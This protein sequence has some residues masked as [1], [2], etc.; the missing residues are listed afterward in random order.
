MERDARRRTRAGKTAAFD[1]FEAL[2][3]LVQRAE[4]DLNDALTGLSRGDAFGTAAG[5]WQRAELGLRRGARG[6]FG[7]WF[8][9][10]NL[11]TR[12]DVIRLGRRLAEIEKQLAR[13]EGN[14][15]A[16]PA[17]A[18]ASAARTR[19]P[20]RRHDDAAS[21]DTGERPRRTRKPPPP[22]PRPLAAPRA[23]P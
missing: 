19:A 20:R 22:A 13:L 11:P 18:A 15:G 4:R 14:L 1:P 16:S 9:S 12:S 3:G 8:S 5:A 6:L 7:W 10:L 17:S 21:A 23:A 2:R